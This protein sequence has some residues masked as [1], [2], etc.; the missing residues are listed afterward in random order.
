MISGINHLTFAVR[1][2]DRSIAFYRDL[3]GCALVAQ[4]PEG[5]YLTAGTLWIALVVD[6]ETRSGPLPEYTHAA[7][8]VSREGLA[9]FTERLTRAQVKVW[10]QNVSEGDSLYILDPDGHK[11]ELHV[12]G[13]QERLS[14]CR[15]H[16]F[17]G[18]SIF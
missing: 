17:P 12:T 1:E 2:L 13:L 5:A 15:A 6:S 14:W 3:L 9:H 7:F 18:L 8:T 10:Q 4:W 16:P 11:L